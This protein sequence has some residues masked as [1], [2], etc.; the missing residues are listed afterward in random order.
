MIWVLLFHLKHCPF[1][2]NSW[3]EFGRKRWRRITVVSAN[4]HNLCLPLWSLNSFFL[5]A[6]LSPSPAHLTVSPHTCQ[7]LIEF[8]QWFTL[9][10]TD[11][12][13]TARH[14]T[15]DE[16]QWR[17][18]P[19]KVWVWRAANGQGVVFQSGRLWCRGL[20]FCVWWRCCSWCEKQELNWEGDLSPLSQHTPSYSMNWLGFLIFV[21]RFKNS[22]GDVT[23]RAA[24]ICWWR[25]HRSMPE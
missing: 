14:V 15:Q 1:C 10:L 8:C 17:Q 4:L 20:R 3:R 6:V 12:R 13:I 25:S 7:E 9:P 2:K 23:P 18:L 21:I 22:R 19:D 24:R 11:S 5:F 16:G